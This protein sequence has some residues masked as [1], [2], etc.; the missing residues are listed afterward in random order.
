M[1]PTTPS[2]WWPRTWGLTPVEFLLHALAACI[3]AGIGNIAAVRGIELRSVES[4]VSGDIDLVGLLG[5][6]DSVRNGYQGIEVKLRIEGD[7]PA[8]QLRE[9]VERSVARSAVFDVLSN[10]TPVSLQIDAG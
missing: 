3:T 4:T 7:A 1:T 10:G 6:D 9:V 5:L 8:E 2:S